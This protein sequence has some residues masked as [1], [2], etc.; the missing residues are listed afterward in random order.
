MAIWAAQAQER[1]PD[2][3]PLEDGDPRQLGDYTLDGRL[4]EGGQ[5]VVYLGRAPSGRRVA[6]KLLHA[7]ISRDAAARARFLREVTAAKRVARFC[8]AQVL[9]VD[10]AGSRP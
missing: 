8:T 7:N 5:G 6:V 2:I 3:Y 1:M 10:L 9:H 4:G